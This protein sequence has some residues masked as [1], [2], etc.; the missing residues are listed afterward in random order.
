M[1]DTLCRCCH[2]P[3]LEHGPSCKNSKGHPM[4]GLM[5]EVKE[6]ERKRKAMLAKRGRDQF[7]RKNCK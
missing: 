2:M 3:I 6:G 5:I 7:K 1:P 4:D